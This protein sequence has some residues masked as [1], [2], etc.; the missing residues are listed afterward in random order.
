M[1][2]FIANC[3]R[4]AHNFNYKLPEKT[5]SFGITIKSGSQHMLE[6]PPEV[7]DHIIRQHEPYGLQHRSKTDKHF[8]GI[9]YSTELSVSESEIIENAEQNLENKDDMSQSILE[10]SAVALDQAVDRAVLQSGET[11]LSDGIQLEVKGEA[12]NQDQPNPPK[13]SKEVRVKK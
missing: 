7:V 11:P 10:A 4:Q 2:L 12:I 9:C 13:V 1:K 8:S 3:S 6:Y 5:Q